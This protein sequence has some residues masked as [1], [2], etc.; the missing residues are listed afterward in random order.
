MDIV[1]TREKTP[2]VKPHP[3]HL[4]MT[5]QWLAADPKFAAMVGDHPMDIK[6]GKD[7]GVYTVGV[8]SGYSKVDDL[9]KAGVDIILNRA[10]DIFAI[11][12]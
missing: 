5:L 6:T 11:L 8:L 2:H 4:R 10:A 7:A 9:K 3:G 1:I 12:V